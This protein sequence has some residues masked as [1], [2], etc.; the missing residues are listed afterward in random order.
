MSA[1]YRSRWRSSQ[2][3]EPCYRTDCAAALGSSADRAERSLPGQPIWRSRN[4]GRKAAACPAA[5]LALFAAHRFVFSDLLLIHKFAGLPAALGP[6]LLTH[7]P[8]LHLAGF[9]LVAAVD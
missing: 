5:C 6:V 7:R 9:A 1:S 3:T 4:H 2:H 8:G